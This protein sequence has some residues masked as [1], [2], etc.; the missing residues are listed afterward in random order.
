MAMVRFRNLSGL[1]K[2]FH[3]LHATQNI[4][5]DLAADVYEENGNLVVEMHVAGIEPDKIDISV[6]GDHLRVVGTRKEVHETENREYH[7]KEIRRG[8]FERILRLPEAVEREKTRAEIRDG[9]LRI[10]L[11]LKRQAESH[12]VT[13]EKH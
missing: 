6:K 12:K 13:V 7:T 5:R 4:G 11:P 10:E 9:V 1:E 8:S 3:E 2:L